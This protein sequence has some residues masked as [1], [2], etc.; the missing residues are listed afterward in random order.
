MNNLNKAVQVCSNE[1]EAKFLINTTLIK[2]QTFIKDTATHLKELSYADNLRFDELP[3][4]KIEAEKKISD[5]I[6]SALQT[7]L[8]RLLLE[9]QQTFVS[10][11]SLKILSED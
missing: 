8:I 3:K 1:N 7:T 10:F 6:L 2:V 4:N 11:I 5:Y 9:I